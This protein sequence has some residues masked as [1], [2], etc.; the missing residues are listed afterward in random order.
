MRT[1]V[2]WVGVHI[3]IL[4]AVAL[5]GYTQCTGQ[6]APASNL[7]TGCGITVGL[8]A[9][10]IGVAQLVYGVVAGVVLA[11]G[12]RTA[13]AQGLFISSATLAVVFTALCFGAAASL[14]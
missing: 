14:N 11:I 13:I 1:I 4:V 12:R 9:L 5:P 8:T 6:S 3:L 2:A 10:A 7:F